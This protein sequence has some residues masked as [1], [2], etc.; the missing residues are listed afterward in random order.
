MG[1]LVGA[2]GVPHHPNFPIL[3]REDT[4]FARELHR[5]YGEVERRLTSVAPDVL[6]IVSSDHFNHYF[7][8]V[9]TFGIG[10]AAETVGPCDR[11]DLPAYRMSVDSELADHIL[12]ESLTNGFD[13]ARSHEFA[14]DHAFVVPYHFLTSGLNVDII[15]VFINGLLP[16]MPSA[17]RC[18][19]IGRA[20]RDA[21]E[22]AD[23][24]KRVAVIASGSVSLDIGGVHDGPAEEH[25]SFRYEGVPNSEWVDEVV[26]LLTAAELTELVRSATSARM[27]S[28]GNIAGEFLNWVVMLGMLEPQ[29]PEF[30]ERQGRLGNVFAAW[31]LGQEAIKDKGSDT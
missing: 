26:E 22:S 1:A 25:P 21:I 24:G 14:L 18:S 31:S 12:R 19:D 6:I 28:A 15:P 3:A 30:V 4:G 20:I 2:V 29:I 5:L 11:P 10:I 13:V 7:A 8:E 27:A 9:P 23:D 17:Q 16:P